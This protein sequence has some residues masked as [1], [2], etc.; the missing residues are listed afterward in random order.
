MDK[1][2]QPDERELR[3]FGLIL[4]SLTIAVFWLV[5]LTLRHREHY[6]PWIVAGI[7]WLFALAAPAQLRGVQRGWMGLGEAL[8][9][10][11]SRVILTLA[12]MIFVAPIGMLMR[13]FGRDRMER[14]FEPNRESYRTPSKPSAAQTMEHPY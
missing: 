14:R 10:F 13:M 12:F 4:G 5:P 6:W 11:N 2:S 3:N 1:Q 9:W 8:G 7:L